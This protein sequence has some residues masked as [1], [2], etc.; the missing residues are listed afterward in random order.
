M[1]TTPVSI[2]TEGAPLATFVQTW[3]MAS[4]SE[5]EEWLTVMRRHVGVLQTQP[6]FVSMS[7]HRSDDDLRVV[8]S[9]QWRSVADFQAAVG[10]REAKAGHDELIQR[11][12]P[13]GGATYTVA[14][15]FAPSTASVVSADEGLGAA[16]RE[17]W[18]KHA[19]Q[20]RVVR[21]NGVELHVAEAG[22]GD[23]VILLHGYPQS[24]EVWRF[25]APDLAKA[26]RVIVPDLRG[27][28]LSDVAE[29]GYEVPSSTSS[30]FFQAFAM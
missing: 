19:F 25:V 23:P 1:S 3:T 16:A 22:Q 6:G 7:I 5:K 11:G 10:S 2:S 14:D 30:R 15:V 27:M 17:R 29:S 13:D 8:V 24:G 28:G 21:V 18:Q 26:H 9:A 20:T 12:S 4:R